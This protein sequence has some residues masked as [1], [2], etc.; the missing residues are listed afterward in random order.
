MMGNRAIYHDGWIA[1]TTPPQGPWMMG[2]GTMPD[3]VNGYHWELYNIDEDYSEYND[4]AAKMPDKLR[5]MQQ[6]FLVEAS[7]YDV[8]P[9]DND[10]LQRCA[11]PASE[12]DRG[13]EPSSPT[14]GRCPARPK[15][16]RPTCSTSR[17]R[18]PPTSR[19]LAAARRE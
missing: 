2:M 15:P 13:A 16:A 6:L 5:D 3:V 10:V 8:L 14:S 19:F 18:F 11:E 4:L 12:R 9:L 1:T 7:K 17:T